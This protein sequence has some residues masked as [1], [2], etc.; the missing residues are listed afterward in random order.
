MEE[1]YVCHVLIIEDE[2]LVALLIQ[3][4]LEAEGATSFAFAATQEEAV[5]AAKAH[6]PALITSD[7]KLL[8]GT[9]PR[10]VTEILAELGP[11]PVLFVTATPEEC[12]P[13][14]PPARILGKPVNAAIL[15]HAFQ[16]LRPPSPC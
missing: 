13:C 3:D 2:A 4:V 1:R 12:E 16:E 14:A 11:V 6:P 9:G 15:A 5:A 7:V 8:E 10:A